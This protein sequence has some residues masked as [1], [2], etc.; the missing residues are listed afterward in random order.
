MLA[1]VILFWSGGDHVLESQAVA[2][3]VD[4]GGSCGIYCSCVV[5]AGF[6]AAF[7]DTFRLEYVRVLYLAANIRCHWS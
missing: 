7:E 4:T 1:P 6:Q 2:L 5:R 3:F